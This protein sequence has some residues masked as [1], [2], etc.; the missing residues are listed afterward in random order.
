M[1]VSVGY[2]LPT[3][4][5]VMAGRPETAPLLALAERAE[6]LGYDSL[7]VGDSLIARPRHEP[8]TLL[9]AVAARTTRPLLGTAVLLPALRHPLVLAHLVATVDRLSEGR[10]VLGVGI[11]ADAPSIRAEFAAVG[12]PFDQRVGRMVEGLELCRQLWTGSPVTFRG[13]YSSVEEA[14][15]GP[16]THRPGGPPIWV[17]GSSEAGQRRAGRRYDGWFPNGHAPAYASGWSTVRS[18]AVDAGRDPSPLVGAAYLTLSVDADA[19][20]ADAALNAFLGA[21]YPMP[22]EVMR[23]AQACYAGPPEGVAEWLSTFVAAG[24]SHL[25]LRFAGEHERHLDLLAGIG[26]QLA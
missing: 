15:L 6:G 26:A 18:A 7:W 22:P 19:S 3:R 5:A 10:V 24:A 8:L 1:T 16:S 17:A 21:Y 20:A 23:R 12:V 25:V 11:A 14:T 9:A 4:E 2:L 13:R